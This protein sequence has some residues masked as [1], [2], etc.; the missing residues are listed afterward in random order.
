MMISDAH[1]A[2]VFRFLDRLQRD[3]PVNIFGAAAI[4]Q[5]KFGLSA[6]EAGA[7]HVA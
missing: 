7:L 2:A 1:R 4:V 3:D 6:A 5:E